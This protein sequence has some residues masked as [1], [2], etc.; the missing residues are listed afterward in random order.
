MVIRL[1]N[2][3]DWAPPIPSLTANTK[4]VLV[5]E[6]SPVLPRYCTSCPEK[7][8]PRK[9]SSLLGLT[10]P[11]WVCPDQRISGAANFELVIV[12]EFGVLPY[13]LFVGR[14]VA[15]IDGGGWRVR[16]QSGKTGHRKPDKSHCE[17]RDRR[18][19]HR[20]PLILKKVI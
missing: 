13:P 6:A 10:F 12:V 8:R 4:S 9:A 5:M 7:L 2:S 17:R 1:A 15:R 11:R 20:I 16:N 18:A 3:P 14:Q 19:A